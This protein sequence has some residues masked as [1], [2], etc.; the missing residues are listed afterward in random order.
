MKPLGQALDFKNQKYQLVVI[1]RHQVITQHILFFITYIF[2]SSIDS[3]YL[4]ISL[5]SASKTRLEFRQ[6]KQGTYEYNLLEDSHA[7]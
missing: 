2:P 3:V 1:E 4:S 6:Q 5:T 7:I